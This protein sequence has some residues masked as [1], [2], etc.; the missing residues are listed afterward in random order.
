M[1]LPKKNKFQRYVDVETENF[2]EILSD[3]QTF[4]EKAQE[5]GSEKLTGAIFAK[6]VLDFSKRL[7]LILKI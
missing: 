4:I 1:N 6:I 3:L 5:F 2:K 7:I